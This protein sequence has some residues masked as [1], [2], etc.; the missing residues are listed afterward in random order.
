MIPSTRPL[1]KYDWVALD[2]NVMFISKG[3]HETK[4]QEERERMISL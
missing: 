2:A 1:K 4:D 3:V